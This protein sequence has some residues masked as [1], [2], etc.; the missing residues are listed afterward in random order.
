MCKRAIFVSLK[1][2]TPMLFEFD[3]ELP[4]Q[5]AFNQQS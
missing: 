1:E 3:F 2:E 4:M 5:L